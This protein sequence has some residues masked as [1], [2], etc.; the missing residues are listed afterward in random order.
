MKRIMSIVITGLILFSFSNF[1]TPTSTVHAESYFVGSGTKDT[2]YQISSESDLRLLSELVS[3]NNSYRSAY[4]VQT[5]DIILTQTFTPISYDDEHA[6]TG[7]YNGNYCS[8]S[9]LSVDTEYIHSGLFGTIQSA[10]IEN[11]SVYGNISSKSTDD[12]STTGGIVGIMSENSVITKCSFNGNVSSVSNNVG[13]IVGKIG[14]GGS[15]LS[16]YSNAIISGNNNIGGLIGCLADDNMKSS[17]TLSHNYVVG[18]VDAISNTDSVGSVIGNVISS[19]EETTIN[20]DVNLYLYTVCSAGAVHSS[21]YHGCTKASEGALKAWFDELG[22]PFIENKETNGFNDGYPIFEWQSTPYAFIGD[23]TANNPY[24]ISSKE[25]L[26]IMRNLINSPYSCGKYNGCYYIQT[27]DIDLQGTEWEPIGKR[28]LNGSEALLSFN[29]NYNGQG[30]EI[31]NLYVNR[32]EKYAGLFGSLNG[33]KFI[34]NLVV[35]GS[36]KSTS[37]SVGGICGEIC[38][39]GGTIRNCAFYGDLETSGKAIGGIAGCLWQSGNVENCYHNGTVTGIKDVGGIVGQVTVGYDKEENASINNCYHV[40]KINGSSNSSG[41]IVG[42]CGQSD[43]YPAN[44]YLNNCYYLN[45]SAVSGYNGVCSVGSVS[46]LTPN[47][48]KNV[49]ADLGAMFKT[50]TNANYNDG[51]PLLVFQISDGLLGDA[52]LDG[53]VNVADVVMLQKWL[54]GSG[55][56]TCWKNVN[57]YDDD[58]IDVFDLCLMKRYLLNLGGTSSGIPASIK[59]NS[60]SYTMAV[61]QTYKLTSTVIPETEAN[62]KVTWT[63]SNTSIVSVDDNGSIKALSPGTATITAKTLNGNKQASCT[64][65]VLTPSIKLNSTSKSLYINDTATLTATVTP[66][67]AVVKWESSDSKIVTVENGK[68]KAV[69]SGD[70]TITAT[71]TVGGTD[72]SASCKVN[73]AQAYA[74]LD[75]S[76]LS[77]YIGDAYTFTSKVSPSGTKLTWKCSN[78]SVATVN[79]SGKVTAVSNGSATITA[80]F[81]YNGETIK[82]TCSVTVKK[83][84]VKISSNSGSMYPGDTKSLT[85]SVDPSGSSVTWSSSN[86]NVATVS[87]GTITAKSGGSATITASITYAGKTYSD[88][89]SISVGALSLSLSSNSGSGNYDVYDAGFYTDGTVAFSIS[90]PSASYSPSGGSTSW[91]VVGGSGKISGSKLLIT[92]PG[93][94]TARCTLTYKG[95]STYRDYTYSLSTYKTTGGNNNIRSGPGGGYSYL[96]TVPANTTVSLYELS[97]NGDLNSGSLWGRVNY[98]GI[99]GWIIV[100]EW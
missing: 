7:S 8:I 75:K 2:P 100:S 49:A 25:E 13:G 97:M 77:M 95:Y 5:T 19:N 26:E 21:F 79:E 62:A 57:F 44:I 76:S 88:S 58:R 69:S 11:L 92:Q 90:L 20:T 43:S 42:L 46:E 23:G 72:Y 12:S 54:L 30:H 18:S 17:Y 31:T 85:A 61:G 6:F 84:T 71:I 87:G 37:D 45:D 28:Y 91:S 68:I 51:Y 93:T 15:L 64:V 36:V 89:C 73:V 9:D 81:V 41:G 14:C 96:G 67:G 70:A 78:T 10:T 66:E 82:A 80:S 16:N 35:F 56:L 32:K 4:Y 39:G 48:M 34:E 60:S 47:L 50:N 63:S 40:G 99:E 33:N 83:P 1:I 22:S 52:N 65:T 29:G 27:D 55:V 59:L 74:T 94:V 3:T 86:T 24:Q 98:N 53:S 38:D